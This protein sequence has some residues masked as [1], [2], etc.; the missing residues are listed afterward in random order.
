MHPTFPNSG[1]TREGE[2]RILP[3]LTYLHPWMGGR[4]GRDRNL[5]LLP[6]GRERDGIY[7]YPTLTLG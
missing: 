6:T 4:N 3:N 7:P 2:G 1:V 5:V